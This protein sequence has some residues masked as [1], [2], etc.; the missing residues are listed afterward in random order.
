MKVFLDTNVIIDFYDSSR[1]HY[2]P[3]AIVFD[4]AVKG[5]I[6]LFVCSQSFITAF[7]LLRKVYDKTAL[8]N[9]MRLLFKLC[10][11]TSVDALLIE[12][13]LS[14]ERQDFEDAV[15]YLSSQ[16]IDADI[17]LTRDGRGFS[18]FGVLHL[19][20]EEFLDK[21]LESLISSI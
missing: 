19:T 18:E 15:Q 9:S 10:H 13:A 6:E 21:Y 17:I 16:T 7:F 11:V 2:L 5:K 14:K 3:T 20:A 8:Y 1:G 12:K 4:L